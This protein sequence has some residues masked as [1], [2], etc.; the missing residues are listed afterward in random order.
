MV[1][2]GIETS[3]DETALSILKDDVILS[4]IVSSQYFHELY[5]GVVPE[6]A[7]RAHLKV[8]TSLYNEVLKSSKINQSDID[9]IAVTHGPGLIG[10]IL[11]GLN[12]AKALSYSLKVP[13]ISVN[14]I[15]AHLLSVYLEEKKP[16][17]PYIG[18]VVSGG[19]TLLVLVKDIFRYKILGCTKD[20]SAGEAYDKV[21]KMLGLSYPGGPI[22]DKLSKNGDPKFHKFPMPCKNRNDFSFS[23]SGLK[24]SVLYYLRKLKQENP[25]IDFT[26]E[27]FVNNVCASFQESVVSVLSDKLIEA[28]KQ[29][30][31]KSIAVT[32]G[33]SANN[34]LRK[35]LTQEAQKNSLDIYIPNI[36]YSTD[37]ASMIAMVGKFK[38][39]TNLFSK[40]NIT[41][42]PN[43]KLNEI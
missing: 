17:I 1:I 25:E 22:I 41:A 43:L 3:C 38:Y 9:A 2:L 34:A 16:N 40:L 33:V 32:G 35:R 24:T 19:H 37:N 28:A 42:L 6:L 13:L 8:I 7:S 15:E 39:E 11:V 27:P 5:G 20:D 26:S 12:F 4:D 14:H 30:N 29:Y 36:K 23:F 10:S 18:L 31:V 21:A